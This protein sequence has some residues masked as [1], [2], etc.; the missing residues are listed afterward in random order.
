M[1]SLFDLDRE[2]MEIKLAL[3][4]HKAHAQCA[5]CQRHA[6]CLFVAAMQHAA[7]ANRDLVAY[8]EVPPQQQGA[9]V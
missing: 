9:S 6:P 2:Y 5:Q 4:Q 3:A 1:I 8:L 7:V